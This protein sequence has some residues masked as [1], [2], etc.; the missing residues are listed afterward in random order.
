[1]PN[2]EVANSTT[3]KADHPETAEARKSAIVAA[4]RTEAGPIAEASPD[5]APIAAEDATTAFPAS[6]TAHRH[7]KPANA[8]PVRVMPVVV[9]APAP[10]AV[11]AEDSA[12]EEAAEGVAE[13]DVAVAAK[14]ILHFPQKG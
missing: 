3:A 5:E 14:A 10:P 9:E 7:A 2:G 11:E 8:E 6:A 12:E 4:D 1:M 13:A